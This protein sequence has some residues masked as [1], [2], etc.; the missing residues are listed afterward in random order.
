MAG[1]LS[2]R[3]QQRLA[4][5]EELTRRLDRVHSLVEQIATTKANPEPL[6]VPLRRALTQLKRQFLSTGFDHQSQLAGGMEIAAGR[7]SGQR[8]K[9][10]ILREGVAS[11]KFQLEMEE[12]LVRIEAEKAAEQPKQ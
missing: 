6:I 4:T 10:R 8:T 11:L 12:R 5:I 1:K 3:A 2:A 9:A 7:G